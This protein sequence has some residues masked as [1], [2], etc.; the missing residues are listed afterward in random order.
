MFSQSPA[1][2][3]GETAGFLMQVSF[4]GLWFD[5]DLTD[6][7]YLWVGEGEDTSA[8]SVLAVAMDVL[9]NAML[10]A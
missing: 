9:S 7:C 3:V 4:Q 8:Y 6:I 5:C 2:F 10:H 1:G